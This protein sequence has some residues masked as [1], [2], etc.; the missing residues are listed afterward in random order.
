MSTAC[1]RKVR[2]SLLICSAILSELTKPGN[3]ATTTRHVHVMRSLKGNCRH[4]CTE[5]CSGMV[6]P[7]CGAAGERTPPS[8]SPCFWL[9][10]PFTMMHAMQ[11]LCIATSAARVHV[12]APAQHCASAPCPGMPALRTCKQALMLVQSTLLAAQGSG[13]RARGAIYQADRTHWHEAGRGRRRLH[14]CWRT[15]AQRDRCQALGTG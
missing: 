9:H 1:N 5:V 7:G 14:S 13:Q 10:F 6:G 8:A 2:R 4:Q 3:K 11:N 12:A 15:Y